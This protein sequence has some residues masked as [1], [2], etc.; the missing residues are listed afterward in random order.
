MLRKA[1]FRTMGGLV[2]LSPGKYTV[3]F[4]G[5]AENSSHSSFLVK[6]KSG[7]GSEVAVHLGMLLEIGVLYDI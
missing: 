5:L 6:G 1:I 7:R 4:H 3:A 2:D